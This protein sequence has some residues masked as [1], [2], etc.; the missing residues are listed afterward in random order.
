MKLRPRRKYKLDGDFTMKEKGLSLL[1]VTEMVMKFLLI[2]VSLTLVYYGVFSLIIDTDVEKRLKEE[3]RA[4]EKI[5]DDVVRKVGILED[6]TAGLEYKDDQLYEAVFHTPA[7]FD[8]RIASINLLSVSDSLKEETMEAQT[9]VK[10]QKNQQRAQDI[11]ADFRRIYALTEQDD[12]VTPPMRLPLSGFNYAR[13][14]AGVGMKVSPFTHV[15]TT[16][17]GIDLMAASGDPVV[18]AAD[19]VVHN[20]VH[21]RKTQGNVIVLQHEGGYKTSYAHLSE[22]KV[23]R[24]ARVKKGQVIATVGMSGNTFAPHLHYEVSRDTLTLDPMAYFFHDLGPREYA[25]M[26][27][28]STSTGRSMD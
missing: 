18:A 8:T 9:A 24:G 10:I 6:V 21:S 26:V 15:P 7:P 12:F 13:T 27:I 3:N 5:Y 25:D 23:R 1:D 17:Y 16:H 28:I 2:T 19:G 22:I 20:V 11:E 4:Y 14:G